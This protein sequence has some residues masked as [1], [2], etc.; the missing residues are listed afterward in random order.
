M[1]VLTNYVKTLLLTSVFVIG[2]I[3]FSS[4]TKNP[5]DSSGGDIVC[6]DGEAWIEEGKN[7]G[8]IFT[9]G[10]DLIAVAVTASGIG[11]GGKVGTYS[12]S[13]GKLTLNYDGE[14]VPIVKTYKVSGGKLTLT[15]GGESKV[16]EK[17]TGVRIDA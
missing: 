3:S 15:G 6:K 2:A 10:A 14:S 17:K 7:F 8:Y 13:G 12:A 4:C 1:T 16:Y 9:E 5:A 11:S